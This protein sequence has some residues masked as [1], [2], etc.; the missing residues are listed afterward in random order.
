VKPIDLNLLSALRALIDEKSVSRA[1]R[2][3]NLSPSA[4]SRTLGRIQSTF[5]DKVL[6]RAGRAMVVTATAQSLREPL[7]TILTGVESLLNQQIQAKVGTRVFNI[8]ANDGFIDS[9]AT[10]IIAEAYRKWPEVRIRF[11]PKHEKDA[12]SLRNGDIDLE[13]GVLGVSGPEIIMR[14]LFDDRMV[15]VCRKGHPL[16]KRKMT[17]NSYLAFPHVSVSRKGRFYGPIDDALR[18]RGLQRNVI[19]VVPNFSSGLEL[20]KTSDWI[21][22]VPEKHT[23]HS[24]QGLVTFNLPVVT[25]PL[26][27]SL[28][29]HPRMDSDPLH[30]HLRELVYSACREQTSKPGH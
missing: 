16:S 21:V 8:S 26:A 7:E 9:F 15:G 5:G 14:K 19:A 18:A 10:P 3:L 6:V 22:Q 20:I 12:A 30:K 2:K 25:P 11:S 23:L 29:W 28:M 13:M 17:L 4:M 27:I 24:R 1:A